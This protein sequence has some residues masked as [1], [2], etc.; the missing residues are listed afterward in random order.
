MLAV[1]VVSMSTLEKIAGKIKVIKRK[2]V[3]KQKELP[4]KNK[5]LRI[6]IKKEKRNK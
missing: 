1:T 4:L 5:L 3:K 2:I 6:V